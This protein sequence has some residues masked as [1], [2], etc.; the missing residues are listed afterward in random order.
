MIVLVCVLS[1]AWEVQGGTFYVSPQGNDQNPGTSGQPWRTIAQANASLQPGDTVLV[2]EGTYA[3]QIWPVRDGVQG[4]PIVYAAM[5]GENAVIEGL[6]GS[7]V[8]V[9]ASD[10]S[11]IEGFTIRCQAHLKLL[12]TPE[13]WVHIVGN[14]ITLRRCR[15]VAD[16]DAA[17]NYGTLKATSRGIVVAGQH[18]LVE[19]CYVRGQMMGV[20]VAGTLPRFTILR[21]DTLVNHGS[22]NIVILS[23]ENDSKFDRTIQGTLIEDCVIDTS[24]DEDNIQWEPNYLD[25]TQP[26]NVGTIVRRCRLGHAA[27]NCLDFKGAESV[28]IDSCFLYSSNGDNN[29]RFDG[30]DDNGG[31]GIELGSGEVS[32]YVILRRS[33]IWDNHTGVHMYDGYR[34]YNNVF[35]NNRRSYRGSNGDFAGNDFAGASIW[36][37]PKLKRAFVN[38]IIA[39]QPNRGVLNLDLDYGANFYLNNN[40]YYD[41][42]GPVRFYHSM[43]IPKT[44]TVGLPNWREIL[45]TYGGYGYLGGKD[46][47]SIEVNPQFINVPTFPVDYD[48]SW[49]FGL[50]P[51][52]PAIDAGRVVTNAIGS[53]SGSTTLRV[54]D[55]RFFCDGFGVTDGDLIKIGSAEPVTIVSIDTSSN[56]ISIAAARTWPDGAG[57]HL[58]FEGSAPDIGASE[59]SSGI[60]QILSPPQLSAPSDGAPNLLTSVQLAWHRAT[61]ALTYFLQVAANSVFS[62]LVTNSGALTDTVYAL[63]GLTGNTTYY[64]RVR[65]GNS[66][67]LSAWSSVLS[68]AT[69]AIGIVPNVPTTSGPA[70]GTTGVTTNPLLSWN[71]VPG[72]L[73]YAVQLSSEPA[74][75]TT[76]VD[77]TEITGTSVLVDGLK[78][79]T[80]Y[81]W[82]VNAT[83]SGGTSVWSLTA[84]LTT[85]A[86][87]STL[88]MNAVTNSDFNSGTTGW[89]FSTTGGGVLSVTSPGYQ[90]ENAARIIV[91]D[92]GATTQLFQN[93]LILSPDSTYRL[94]FAARSTS[95]DDCDVTVSKSDPPYS[96]YGPSGELVD[97]RGAWKSFYMDFKPKNFSSPVNDVRLRFTFTR[98]AT[99]GE[100]Y[101]IDD[102]RLFAIGENTPPPAPGDLPA[103]FFLDEIY[104]NPFNPAT[105]IRYSIP[106]DVHVVIRVYNVLG[107][108][109][110]TQVDGLQTAGTHDAKLDLG[111]FSSGMYLCTLQA[112]D[113]RQTR[114]LMYVK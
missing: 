105:T 44:T 13:Y 82:R 5:P 64:W 49:N 51:N 110:M 15:V 73:S 20:V 21:F 30:L 63:T 88:A 12:E 6:P 107:Q 31:P 35:L 57:V 9:I 39:M 104:P 23:H 36:N 93:G 97:L 78:N 50:R 52:S 43:T 94:T 16:G 8:V 27:E 61:G 80:E 54:E 103:D 69:A 22:S 55:A 53:G 59:F 112:G 66:T 84:S 46:S 37:R 2:R 96:V 79:S 4:S 42:E 18:N 68:F 7:L 108:L 34:Y 113:Y 24:W 41:P 100:A 33:V 70:T 98:T 99:P 85:F 32:R 77:Q 58:A 74:F 102:V 89:S 62:P 28:L 76:L 26:Y 25:H 11:V 71:G 91:A 17:F 106:V 65:S 1:F 29:G 56:T 10:Y 101:D 40:I 67:G 90:S 109:V 86:L 72:A 48:S 60:G 114:K 38:N 81:F 92:A 14:H 75:A 111:K 95:G 83:G 47:S 45:S 19:H 3:E 87:P